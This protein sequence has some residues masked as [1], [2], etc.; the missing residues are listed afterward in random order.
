M[1]FPL[2]FFMH[3][4]KMCLK[5]DRCCFP[6]WLCILSPYKSCIFV[7]FTVLQASLLL[8]IWRVKCKILTLLEQCN[9]AGVWSNEGFVHAATSRTAQRSFLFNWTGTT[10]TT[11]RKPPAFMTQQQTVNMQQHVSL[12]SFGLMISEMVQVFMWSWAANTHDNY[13]FWREWVEKKKG[14]SLTSQV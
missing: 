9:V 4:L 13:T 7:T 12:C 1:A 10:K 11:W 2:R 5:T 8:S 3:K 14:S 6:A